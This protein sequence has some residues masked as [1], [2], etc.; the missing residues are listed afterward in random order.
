MLILQNKIVDAELEEAKAK[1]AEL[2]AKH[3]RD[4]AKSAGRAKA[5]PSLGGG[6]VSRGSRHGMDPRI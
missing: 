3:A 2:Q 4:N 1:L 5:G 6:A